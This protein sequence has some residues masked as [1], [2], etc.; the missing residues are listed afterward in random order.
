MNSSWWISSYVDVFYFWEILILCGDKKLEVKKKSKN[1]SSLPT[2]QRYFLK[3]DEKFIKKNE[4]WAGRMMNFFRSSKIHHDE[5]IK[6]TR[7]FKRFW[8]FFRV[9]SEEP[10]RKK[11]EKMTKSGF[12]NSGLIILVI[13]L[14]FYRFLSFFARKWVFFPV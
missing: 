7:V 12:K 13:F 11:R 10:P 1:S 8:S 3:N 6:K 9:F 14:L 5:F 4:I 2:Q